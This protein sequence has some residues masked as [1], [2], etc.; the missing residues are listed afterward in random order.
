MDMN[1]R[2]QVYKAVQKIPEGKV[3]TYGA[4]AAYI[5]RP[6]ASRMVGCQLHFNNDP[7]RVPCYRVVFKDGSLSPAFAFGGCDEQR[8]LLEAE[9]VVFLDNGKV[10]MEKCLYIKSF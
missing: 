2:E 1:F 8:R 6:H 4:V 5:G 3:S 9:N 7:E 10:D